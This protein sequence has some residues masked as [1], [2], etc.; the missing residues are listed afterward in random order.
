MVPIQGI[1]PCGPYDNGATTRPPSIEVY[2]GMESRVGIEPTM[3]WVAAIR[4]T[5]WLPAYLG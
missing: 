1:E 2:I 4:L 5:T 3:G